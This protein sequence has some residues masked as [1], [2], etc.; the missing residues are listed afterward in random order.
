MVINKEEGICWESMTMIL[1]FE[2]VM[3]LYILCN[4]SFVVLSCL[5]SVSLEIINVGIIKFIHL[6]SPPSPIFRCLKAANQ[7]EG[8]GGQSRKREENAMLI[9]VVLLLPP[10]CVRQKQSTPHHYINLPSTPQPSPCSYDHNT[11]PHYHPW[12]LTSTR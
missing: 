8:V 9:Y 10:L 7:T 3:Y 4:I 2:V 6:L 11:Y 1:S 5:K 12:S